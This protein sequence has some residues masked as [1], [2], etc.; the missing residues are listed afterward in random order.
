MTL[1]RIMPASRRHGVRATAD[2]NR[3]GVGR[4]RKNRTDQRF[5]PAPRLSKRAQAGTMRARGRILTLRPRSSARDLVNQF[6][7][8]I[9]EVRWQRADALL[10][11]LQDDP[12]KSTLWALIDEALGGVP[13]AKEAPGGR[14]AS[15]LL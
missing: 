13:G 5:G 1:I 7:T 15:S 6:R 4:P 2:S 3:V 14:A 10:L 12:L 9:E 11:A 8:L